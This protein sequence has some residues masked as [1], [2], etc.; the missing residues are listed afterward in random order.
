MIENSSNIT[1]IYRLRDDFLQDI[2]WYFTPIIVFLGLLG[3]CLSMCVFFGTKLRYSSSSIYLGALAISDSGFLV[4]VFVPWLR[5]LQVDLFNRHGFC[6][7]FIYLGYICSFLSVWLVVAFTVERYVAVKWPLR[8]QVWCTVA[9]AKMT[10]TGLTVLASLLT[11]PVLVFSTN[12]GN[13]TGCGLDM[14]WKSWAKAYNTLDVVMTFAMPLTM[15]VIFNTLIARNIY[16]LNHVRRTLTIESDVSNDRAHTPRDRMPQT[17]VTKML[18]IVSSAFFCL[19]MPAFVFRV[20]AFLYENSK[21]PIWFMSA[22]QMCQ[23]L[24]ETSFGINFILYCV[25]GQNFR[26]EMVSM[27][28]KRSSTGR[29]G[30]LI[31]MASHGKQ[32]VSEFTRRYSSTKRPHLVD[33]EQQKDSQETQKLPINK[34]L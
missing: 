32:C 30:T 21:P 14:N 26:R 11:S 4:A 19:N 13:S 2:Q 33:K 10:V 6:Q 16:R 34:E 24:F 3:N 29:S 22:Q 17:K 27:C 28:T 7:F 5:I 9:R 15:I 1:T 8:R 23:L 18:L 25:S 20:I 12:T 31:Q